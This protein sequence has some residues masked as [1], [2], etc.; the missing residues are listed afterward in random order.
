MLEYDAK[1]VPNPQEDSN[2]YKIRSWLD[3]LYDRKNHKQY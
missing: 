3:N 2:Q 1:W